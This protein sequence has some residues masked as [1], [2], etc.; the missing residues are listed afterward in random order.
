MKCETCNRLACFEINK[1]TLHALDE[2]CKSR[3]LQIYEPA[4]V[5]HKGELHNSII[6]R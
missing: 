5:W 2:L 1:H 6:K 4:M 3:G